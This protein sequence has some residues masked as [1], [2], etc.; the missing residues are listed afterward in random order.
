MD[1]KK[2]DLLL[3][4]ELFNNFADL[5][6]DEMIK[7][8]NSISNLEIVDYSLDYNDLGISILFKVP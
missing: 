4:P 1:F 3:S 2:L 5:K 7:F 6:K 8:L